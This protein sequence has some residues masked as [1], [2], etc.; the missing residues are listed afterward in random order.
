MSDAVSV[1]P[2]DVVRIMAEQ[3]ANMSRDAAVWQARAELAE[4]KLAAMETPDA[5]ASR[6]LRD[7]TDGA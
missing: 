7:V 4:R 3:I 6:R 5:S 2:A 1:N